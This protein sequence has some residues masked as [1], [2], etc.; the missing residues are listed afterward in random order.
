MSDA[1][2][3]GKRA[4]KLLMC[5]SCMKSGKDLD[6]KLLKC[7]GCLTLYCSKE[8]QL[9]DWPR[10]KVR[11]KAIQQLKQLIQSGLSADQS[12]ALEDYNKWM[13]SR[14]SSLNCLAK[15]ILPV[16]RFK[17]HFVHLTME[18]RPE[19]RVRFQVSEQYDVPPIDEFPNI[20]QALD[21]AVQRYGQGFN[22][23]PAPWLVFMLVITCSN[24]PN[25]RDIV[26]CAAEDLEF[27]ELEP[28]G[29][30]NAIRKLNSG[31]L[32]DS[33]LFGRQA[34]D[35]ADETSA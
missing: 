13:G 34:L 8:C 25:L 23:A 14:R 19:L 27:H 33:T 3:A 9:A 24:V 18:Y 22:K 26:P 32:N 4:K 31:E 12:H 7:S 29:V 2:A 20:R 28:A 30:I 6:G 1:D 5:E 21:E 16:D 15:S 11:C 35:E 17:T 10:H